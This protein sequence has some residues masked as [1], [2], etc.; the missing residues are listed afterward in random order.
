M[1]ISPAAAAQSPRAAVSAW[2]FLFVLVVAIALT[3]GGLRLIDTLPA[4]WSGEPRSVRAYDTVDEL[5]REVR[6]RL[7]LPAFFPETL[8]WPP[9]RV[10]RSAGPG[11]PTLLAFRDRPSGRERV[12]LCQTLEG[13]APIPA[14]LLAPG[15]IVEQRALEVSGS[16]AALR[17]VR[18]ERGETWTD[19]TW[20]QQSRRIHIRAGAGTTQTELM[21]LARS[22]HRGR[23]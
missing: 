3:A 9:S 19:L 14:R 17:V 13:D 8:A 7:L 4:W 22:L 10:E 18:G 23:P 6:T 1:T 11:K 5:E 21:R 16:P 12:F 2:R 15:T 20:V